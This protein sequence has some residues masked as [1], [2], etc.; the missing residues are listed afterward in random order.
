[1][2][3]AL[4]QETTP[5][6]SAASATTIVSNALPAAALIGS[7][8]EVWIAFP[9]VMVGNVT[10]SSVVDSSGQAYT[11]AGSISSATANSRY[12]VFYLANNQ[13][14]SALSVTVTFSE[15]STYRNVQ[16]REISGAK[17]Q[18]PL[19]FAAANRVG[20]G[21]GTDA[22]S[23]TPMFAT[24]NVLMSG[25]SAGVVG[26]GGSQVAGTGYTG[27]VNFQSGGGF[28]GS[29]FESARFSSVSNKAVTWTDATNGGTTTYL[30]AALAWE[31]SSAGSFLLS[32][33]SNQGGF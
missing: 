33:S 14:N 28:S 29:K 21:T 7:V 30:V 16:V 4:R 24:A 31:E 32:Q 6:G 12:E 11:S 5:V 23:V 27:T 13:Y 25:V 3:I 18:A 10:V 22:I 9:K 8:I 19:G 17:N 1:M 26:S 20:P 15:T 2:A